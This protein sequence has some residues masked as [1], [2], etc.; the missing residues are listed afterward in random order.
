MF[1]KVLLLVE[2]KTAFLG[3]VKDAQKHFERFGY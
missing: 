1:D 3:G 2:G